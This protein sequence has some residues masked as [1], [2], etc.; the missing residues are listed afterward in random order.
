MNPLVLSA[1]ISGGAGLL[2]SLFGKG[3][4]TEY[5]SGLSES[6]QMYRD[7]MNKYLMNKM[8]SPYQYAKMSSATPDALNMLYQTFFGQNFKVPGYGTAGGS[9]SGGAGSGIPSSGVPSG[10][11]NWRQ[12]I[13]MR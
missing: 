1:I 13:G 5:T 2:G 11:G 10:E 8:Q 4:E 7:Y 9:T 12:K 3:K 6:D